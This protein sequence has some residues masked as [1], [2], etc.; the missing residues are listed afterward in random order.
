GRRILMLE[1]HIV[2]GGC[3]TTFKRRN[4]TMEVGLHEMDGL[5][6]QDIKLKIFEELGVFDHLEFIKLPEFYRTL[7]ESGS[8]DFVMPDGIENAR[9]ALMQKFP[10][11]ARGIQTYFDTLIGVRSEVIR[12]QS[13]PRWKVAL[14]LPV[15]PLL[16]PML[17]RNM[18]KNL[19][20]FLNAHIG[21]T[22]LKQI[23]LAN[24]GYY[25]DDP[26]SMSMIYYCMAQG[27][28]YSGGGHYI[29]GGSQMLSDYLA[30][31]IRQHGGDIK[32]NQRV[33][34]IIIEDG[35]ARG[36]C[37]ERNH[38]R[39]KEP[40]RAQAAVVIANSAVPNIPDMLPD[41]Y[42]TKLQR[43]IANRVSSCSLLSIY[44]GFKSP[45]QPTGRGQYA[46]F[47]A[48]HTI[49]DLDELTANNR[50][51]YSERGFVFV[52]YSR[53][54]AGLSAAPRS[55]GAFCCVD[56]LND[57]EGLSA[58]DYRAKKE[59]V[60]LQFFR[61]MERILPGFRERVETYEVGTPHTIRRY[62]WNPGGSV[63]GFAQIPGQDGLYRLPAKSPIKGLYFAS[64]YTFPGGGFTGAILS[65]WF[66]A[67]QV[68]K[69][70]KIPRRRIKQANNRDALQQPE[71]TFK[72]SGSVT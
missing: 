31:I 56:Y 13:M 18:K 34:S 29:K 67:A 37:F 46:T 26:D 8:F 19:G 65:G 23:L 69:D 28:Y 68:L 64:A 72:P 42:R 48:P 12:L 17:V 44:V 21:D 25:H 51:P 43:S 41:P 33:T 61:R 54:D 24:L 55:V 9:E 66:C 1:Q 5:D 15:F 47:V 30:D 10:A 14:A 70:F 71:A 16:F 11:E 57:W 49:A 6:A 53:I 2:P 40:S 35:R 63:Y 27:G 7:T 36:V 50:A 58:A 32:F 22:E 45:P 60:A 59:V 4:F 38:G 3:A 20:Q 62:T 52:D 39:H